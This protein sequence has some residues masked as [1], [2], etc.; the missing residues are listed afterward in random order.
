MYQ[1]EDQSQKEELERMIKEF[2]C[3]GT[4]LT[5]TNREVR[6]VERPFLFNFISFQLDW[7]SCIIQQLWGKDEPKIACIW[8]CS[9]TCTIESN[10]VC[11]GG[12]TSSLMSGRRTFLPVT[13]IS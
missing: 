3:K 7:N 2:Y 12:T 10:Y 6:S 4:P 1:T 11:S 5:P 13:P 8:G 9:S